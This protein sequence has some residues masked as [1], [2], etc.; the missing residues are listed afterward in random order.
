MFDRIRRMSLKARLVLMTIGLCV[1]FIWALAAMSA[2]VLRTQLVDV[3]S[4][5]QLAATR[6]VAKQLDLQLQ[7]NIQGLMHLARSMPDALEPDVLHALLAASPYHHIA[8]S[9]GLAISGTDGIVLADYPVLP[10]RKGGYMGD[11]DYFKQVV[12]TGKPYVAKPIVGRV[13]QRTVLTTSV[14]VFGKD[15]KLR[16]VIS[17][18]TDLNGPN[19]LG[20]VTDRVQ[21]GPGEFFVISLRDKMIMS[22]TDSRRNMQALPPRGSN[23]IF[24]RMSDGFEG[25]G[26][27]V[28]SE[29]SS[30]LYSGVHVPTAN[31]LVLAALPTEVAFKPLRTL[32]AYL[33]GFA[34]F[35]T[36]TA[37][38]LIHLM[39]RRL[40]IPLQE[41]G[42]LIQR[43]TDG[44]IP[45]APIPVARDDEVGQLVH[46]FNQL[47][48][49]R[50]Q[51]EAALAESERRFRVLVEQA[52]DGIFVQAGG[53]LVYSNSAALRLFGAASSADLLGRTLLSLVHPDSREA[54]AQ[55]IAKL[56]QNQELV[57]TMEFTYLKLDGTPIEVEI[58]AVPFSFGSENGSLAFVRDV[59]ARKLAAQA[60][61]RMNRALLLLSDC[62]TALVH[63]DREQSLLDQICHLVVAKGG[64]RMAWVGYAR[65]DAAGTIKPVAHG[66]VVDGFLD[67]AVISWGGT[68]RGTSPT[69]RAIRTG[70]TQINHDFQ[71]N[72]TPAI[73]REAAVARGFKSSIALPLTGGGR[74]FGA[75]AIYAGA[76][77]AFQDDEVALLQELANN[78]AYGIETLRNR[79]QREVVEEK[80]AFLAHH[81]AL[82]GLP[83]RLLL[84]DRFDHAMTQALRDH[85]KIA[86]LFLDLDDFKQINDSLGHAMGDRLLVA[87]TERLRS[88]VRDADTISRQGGDEFII[89]MGGLAETGTV[90]RIAQQILEA[91]SEPFHVDDQQVTT[92][93][94]IGISLYP[95]DADAFDTLLKNADSALYH[96]KDSG[97]NAYSF[98]AADM[99]V[100]ALARMQLQNRLRSALK[101]GEFLLHYQPQLAIGSGRVVG[102]EALLRWQ[103]PDSALVPPGVFIPV[104]EQSGLIVAIGEW[105]VNEACRQGAAWQASGLTSLVV[106]LNISAMQ[107]RRGNILETVKA[108][109]E[110]SGLPAHCLE[111]ELTES[112]LLQDINAAMIT[113]HSLKQL[114]VKLAIDD[115]GTGYS[116]LSYLKRLAVD[117][118]KIDQSFV[119]DIADDPDDAAIVNAIVQ[120]GHTLQLTVIAE[121]VETEGQLAFL[122][123][124]GC[125]EAQG[126][127]FSRPV[128]AQALEP[129]LREVNGLPK[130][131]P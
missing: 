116:S 6:R 4:D 82:T 29:G 87:L 68:Q 67:T 70:Q 103:P 30:K 71:S 32:Q 69:G 118:L 11:R 77:G 27:A 49:D 89:L 38:V 88:C 23:L 78:L 48:R 13:L 43:M 84:R 76:E 95:D 35:L 91:I 90:V 41:T 46:K 105:V 63:A 50:Q 19:F 93:F 113:L 94:S 36:L 123:E 8:F 99:N 37:A 73:W 85:S 114:G 42:R 80:L 98:F 5:Q 66:G 9:A 108:A 101:N 21:T 44:E 61:Q 100:D 54:V 47:V 127:L 122:T 55:R 74:T 18:Y 7:D 120:L 130:P 92:S 128:P 106:G 25:S 10:G 3:L 109:L 107:F 119:R 97:R 16:A 17:G 14:P 60:S 28:S 26:V 112:V 111:L 57:P 22:A 53:V 45:L 81:D 39:L 115:F 15:G 12:E 129:M 110:A 52:P 75:L 131:Q 102:V 2:T 31:W 62:N 83:N 124:S 34:S 126:Y 64:Y 58:S 56:N 117:K 59:G 20:F 24:D 79:Q 125:D 51:H 121:G 96:A 40:L 33:Y 72:G 104:A 65:D 86:L 1:V